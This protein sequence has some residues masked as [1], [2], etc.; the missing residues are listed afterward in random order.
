MDLAFDPNQTFFRGTDR[1]IKIQRRKIVNTKPLNGKKEQVTSTL[2]KAVLVQG[3][4][5][6]THPHLKTKRL[7]C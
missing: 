7:K 3:M 6:K 2:Y 4:S 1:Y 5:P